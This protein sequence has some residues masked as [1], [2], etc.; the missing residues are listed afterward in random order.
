MISRVII[1]QKIHDLEVAITHQEELVRS[2]KEILTSLKALLNSEL[3]KA[4]SSGSATIRESESTAAPIQPRHLVDLTFPQPHAS[5]FH[6]SN[7]GVQVSIVSSAQKRASPPASSITSNAPSS[8]NTIPAPSSSSSVHPFKPV[9]PS[10]LGDQNRHVNF[11]R[12]RRAIEKVAQ[13]CT[14]I[15]P[16]GSS[17]SSAHSTSAAGGTKRRLSDG[18]GTGGV[19]DS[20]IIDLQGDNS[21]KK[22]TTEAPSARQSPGVAVASLV[23]MAVRDILQQLCVRKTYEDRLEALKEMHTIHMMDARRLKAA[24]EQGGKGVLIAW[25]VALEQSDRQDKTLPVFMEYAVSLLQS[26]AWTG[27]SV[28]RSRVDKVLRRLFKKYSANPDLFTPHLSNLV[29]EAWNK[30]RLLYT[31]YKEEQGDGESGGEERGLVAVKEEKT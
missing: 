3:S 26:A 19:D 13:F 22:P 15:P 27:E 5:P 31:N 12:R 8:A 10:S 4:S 11:S 9:L 28:A 29:R 24:L 6:L 14:T 16:M 7:N 18:A 17:A 25:L 2:Q 20:Q 30:F 21:R 1:E 23:D